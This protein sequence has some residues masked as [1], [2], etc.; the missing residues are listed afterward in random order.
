METVQQTNRR[1]KAKLLLMRVET[2]ERLGPTANC[3]AGS[4]RKAG[5]SPSSQNRGS[6]S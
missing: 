6:H 3:R 2:L 1:N 5:T 4:L